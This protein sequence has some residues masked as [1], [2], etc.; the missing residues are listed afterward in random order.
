MG[1]AIKNLMA[2]EGLT[3]KVVFEQRLERKKGASRAVTWDKGC[4]DRKTH[5]KP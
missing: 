5:A 1:T 3:E 2:K 4:A